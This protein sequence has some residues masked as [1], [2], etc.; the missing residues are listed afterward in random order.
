MQVPKNKKEEHCS[1]VPTCLS[2]SP[3]KPHQSFQ[4]F[5]TLPSSPTHLSLSLSS[6]LF[7]LCLPFSFYFIL[8]KS[9]SSFFDLIG[10][11]K[12]FKKRN[13]SLK[14]EPTQKK[15]SVDF[16]S[17]RVCYVHCSFCTTILA[18]ISLSSLYC[19]SFSKER[20][21]IWYLL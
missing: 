4:I 7:L 8:P 11:T 6:F 10:I 15:M 12:S 18:V 3:N 20:V 17:E 2:S 19:K 21:L 5:C 1:I 14:R 16:S 9:N 13:I